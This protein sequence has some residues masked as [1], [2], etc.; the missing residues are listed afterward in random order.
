M[1]CFSLFISP[2]YL[3]STI[4]IYT[5]SRVLPLSS[6]SGNF[7]ELHLCSSTLG[8]SVAI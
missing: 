3:T 5:S 2:F 8:H 1:L 7:W 4:L 6:I